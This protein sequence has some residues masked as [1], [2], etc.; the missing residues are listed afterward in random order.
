MIGPVLAAVLAVTPP[1]DFQGLLDRERGAQ[2]L[3]GVSA[4]VIRD[5]TFLY[6]GGSGVADIE[7]GR[8]M[9]ADTVLYA[10]SLTKI[11]TA[12]LALTLVDDG[13]LALDTPVFS[14]AGGHVAT[15]RDLLMH[16]SGLPREGGFDYWFT[17]DFPDAA[18]LDARLAEATLRFEPGT[19]R[20]YSNV[21]YA[22]LGRIIERVGEAPYAELLEQRILE[23]LAMQASGAPGP[24]PDVAAGYTPA[25]RLLPDPDRP[26][27]GVGR[28]VGER[29]ERAYHDARAMT[30]AFGAFASARDLGRFARFLLGYAGEGV[31]SADM[32]RRMLERQASGWGLGLRITREAGRTLGRHDGWFAA[33]RTHFLV[34][35]LGGVAVVVMANSD[36]ASAS[37][38]ADK[39]Y[40]AAIAGK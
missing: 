19:A 6:A 7:S 25:G 31:L 34:D 5:G 26:F 10:G 28:R 22:A 13:L 29:H 8:P 17:A 27:A 30:P 12:A 39:L 33:H 16:A 1:A 20:Y 14:A 9:T 21:G 11:L 23:P 24:A 38:I 3:P 35:P 2:Q 37:R 18:E 15:T 32:R 4:V 40:R 36:A